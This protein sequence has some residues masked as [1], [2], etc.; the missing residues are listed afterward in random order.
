M[1]LPAYDLAGRIEPEAQLNGSIR[2]QEEREEPRGLVAE[3]G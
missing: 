1:S 2:R 3:E